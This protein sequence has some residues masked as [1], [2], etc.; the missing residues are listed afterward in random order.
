MTSHLSRQPQWRGIAADMNS[1]CLS[2]ACSQ[3]DEG[4]SNLAAQRL[5][6]TPAE[7]DWRWSWVTGRWEKSSQLCHWSPQVKRAKHPKDL[8]KGPQ[9][10]RA[11]CKFQI[12][13]ASKD[14]WAF[15]SFFLTTWEWRLIRGLNQWM[16]DRSQAGCPHR[17]HPL[18]CWR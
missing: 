18:T 6:D 10:E 7:K 8:Q 9:R 1:T 12:L 13:L 2:T 15:H 11:D 16:K 17:R 5:N 14:P 3:K 4:A